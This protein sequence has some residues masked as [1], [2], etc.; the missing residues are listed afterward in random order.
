LAAN[1][2]FPRGFL[3]RQLLKPKFTDIILKRLGKPGE[4]FVPLFHNTVNATI[5][6]GG[7]KLNVIPDEIE[8]QLDVRIL[9][10][11]EPDDVIK[12]LRPII[13]HDVELDL[14][15]YDK[16]PEEPDMG[17]FELLAGVLKKADPQGIPVPFLLPGSSDARFLSRLGIQTYG[18]IPMQLPQEMNFNKT[19]HAANERIPIDSLTFGTN[20][21][22]QVM[23]TWSS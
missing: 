8:V 11:F 13:G 7:D 19:I 18:F 5:V 21:L 1:L 23:Q 10:G 15:V 16:G 2:A 17:L 3:L 22:F 20:T 9:P 12:E 6:R 4:A 14:I